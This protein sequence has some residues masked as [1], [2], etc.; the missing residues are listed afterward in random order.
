MQHAGPNARRAGVGSLHVASETAV[1]SGGGGRSVGDGCLWWAVL[2]CGDCDDDGDGELAVLRGCCWLRAQ[3]S[4]RVAFVPH[5]NLDED[6][7]A[8]RR[9]EKRASG[10]SG[11]R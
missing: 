2:G 8:E 6:C 9:G 11:W 10:W 7:A 3:E 5:A 4:G 1:L